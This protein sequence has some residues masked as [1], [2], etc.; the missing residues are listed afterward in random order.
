M[1]EIFKKRSFQ[2]FGAVILVLIVLMFISAGRPGTP[3]WVTRAVATVV[4]PFQKGASW[5]K[6]GIGNQIAFFSEMNSLEEKNEELMKENARLSN[7][8]SSLSQLREE[9]ER[10]RATLDFAQQNEQFELAGARVIAKDVSNYFQSF[11]IDK[12]VKDG[13][14]VNDAVVDYS[15]LVGYVY[16]A[17]DHTAKVS[18]LLDENTAVS[19]KV[20]RTGDSTMLKGDFTLQKDGRCKLTYVGRD[21]DII[22]GDVLQTSGLGG[23]YPA[24]LMVGRV[25]EVGKDEAEYM[26]YAI[27]EPVVDFAHLYEVMVITNS[28]ELIEVDE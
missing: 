26:N 7:E 3:G 17:A 2:V 19:V 4:S 10:L 8:L 12:G 24:G 27:V 21:A 16:E 5:V 11:V 23:R 9:N 28:P 13:V 15:G 1:I 18:T 20:V 6:N 25:A 22:S 14:K